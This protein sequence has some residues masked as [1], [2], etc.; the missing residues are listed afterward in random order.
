[1]RTSWTIDLEGRVEC[2][3]VQSLLDELVKITGTE[4]RPGILFKSVEREINFSE[5]SILHYYKGHCASAPKRVYDYLIRL[6]K[7]LSEDNITTRID[8]QH[9]RLIIN[10]GDF[11]KHYNT[12]LGNYRI[13]EEKLNYILKN[14]F[15]I[16][17]DDIEKYLC[18]RHM[19]S[20]KMKS[21]FNFLKIFG[22]KEKMMYSPSKVY[23]RGDYLYIADW[24]LGE[25]IEVNG[26]NMKVDFHGTL[27]E[28]KCSFVQE[29][30]VMK[31]N[32]RAPI[33]E[34]YIH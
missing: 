9:K 31:S 17:N 3:K 1:M 25:V 19:K 22:N 26:K 5:T 27:R 23:S 18:S 29:D 21:L 6:K 4:H 8:T 14:R 28:L 11:E 34:P 10:F 16:N 13:S 2:Q 7:R 15:K 20:E 33:H 24:E 12:V 30:D 32:F